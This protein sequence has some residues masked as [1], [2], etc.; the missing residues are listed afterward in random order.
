[1]SLSFK[2]ATDKLR[3]PGHVLIE[4]RGSSKNQERHARYYVVPGGP[5]TE[6]TAQKILALSS[7]HEVDRGLLDGI[8]QSWSLRQNGE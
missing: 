5:I 4:L 2:R 1:M 7:C 3:Q 6:Q 8:P